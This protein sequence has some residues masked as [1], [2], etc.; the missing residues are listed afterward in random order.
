MRCL[1]RPGAAVLVALA[2]AGCASSPSEPPPTT[3]S[4][5][6]TVTSPRPDTTTD[7]PAPTRPATTGTKTPRTP[8]KSTTKGPTKTTTTAKGP[9]KPKGPGYSVNHNPDGSITR[10]NGCTPITWAFN[11]AHAPAGALTDIKAALTR[12]SAA[13]G[14]TF[15]R[16]A[17]T[18]TIPTSATLDAAPANLIIAWA[19]PGT[20]DLL[21][22]TTEYARGGWKTTPTLDPGTGLITWPITRGYVLLDTLDTTTWKPGFGTGQRRGTLLLHELGHAIGLNHTTA[23]GQVM[24]PAITATS[25][26]TWGTGDRKGLTKVGRPAACHP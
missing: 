7:T 10:W 13:T 15:T 4:A 25:T 12:I 9:S 1:T 24:N 2:V 6:G 26:S 11:P 14:L 5:T 23:P 20:T 8:A 18:T 16:T 19:P 3:R 17:N 21:D 22:N